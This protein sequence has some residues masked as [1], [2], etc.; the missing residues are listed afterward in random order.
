MVLQ[1][2]PILRVHHYTVQF[3]RYLRIQDVS[4]LVFTA[5]I[6]IIIVLPKKQPRQEG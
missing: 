5:S 2:N 6:I 3:N 1:G 4:K